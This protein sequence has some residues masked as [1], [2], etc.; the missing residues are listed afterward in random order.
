M[1]LGAAWY[2]FGNLSPTNYFEIVAALG[3]RYAE[4]P[5]YGFCL[6][7]EGWYRFRAD[8][9]AVAETA[10]RV[11]VE[12]VSGVAHTHIGGWVEGDEIVRD[13]VELAVILAK[14]AIDVG[15][16]LGTQ[17]VRVTEPGDLRP[18]H[19]HLEEEYVQSY[20][21]ALRALGEYAARRDVRIAIENTAL[22][23]VRIKRIVDAA[24]H[25]AVGTLYDP[26]NYYRHGE[27]PLSALKKLGQRV[28]YCHL[29]DAHFPYPAQEPEVM[30]RVRGLGA[31]VEP[32][33]W[34]RPLGEGNIDWGPI[35]AELATFYDGYLCLEHDIRDS[36]VR[37]TRLG[38]AHVRRIAAEYGLEIE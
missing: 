33:W 27:D 35:L 1:K 37:G 32:W 20:G 22:S 2:G 10:R 15:A 8:I 28:I 5:L 14:R 9:Q 18:D 24:D 19:V 7:G 23:S 13:G 4:V 3:L 26:C 6:G 11:G 34:I 38:M 31:Q 29:K 21:Q 16:A 36:V 17:V 30:P 25:P 12:I